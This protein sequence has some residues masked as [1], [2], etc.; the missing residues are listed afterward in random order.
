MG[1][2][3][4]E[5]AKA[6]TFEGGNYGKE[7]RYWILV[8]TGKC[9]THQT[10]KIEQIVYEGNVVRVLDPGPAPGQRFKPTNGGNE[11][12]H[13]PGDPY[14]FHFGM[15]VT[16]AA[17][18][19]RKFLVVAAGIDEKSL[20]PAIVPFNGMHCQPNTAWVPGQ[21]DPATGRPQAIQVAVG[22]MGAVMA[23][24][25]IEYAVDQSTSPTQ[26]AIS[27][28]VIEVIGKGVTTQGKNGGVKRD[29][30]S[31]DPIRRVMPSE[32]RAAWEQIAEPARAILTRNGRFDQMLNQEQMQRGQAAVAAR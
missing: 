20:P 15:W 2:F 12:P 3:A 22:T 25:P 17:G 27:G 31:S 18:R 30:I 8:E 10:K 16:G 1:V 14:T 7:G 5:V 28:T 4:K 9:D 19:L 26:N 13:L 11:T 23:S 6:K 21:V 32:I 24:D 29:I